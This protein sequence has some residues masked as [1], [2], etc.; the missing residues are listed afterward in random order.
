[1]DKFLIWSAVLLFSFGALL[2]FRPAIV[3]KIDDWLNKSVFPV[4][5]KMRSSNTVSGIVLAILG[6]IVLYLAIKH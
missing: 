5:D 1:M 6:I 3:K 4:D 2:V